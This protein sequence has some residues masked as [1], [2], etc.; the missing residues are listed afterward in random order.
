MNGSRSCTALFSSQVTQQTSRI[1]IFRPSV[2]GWYFDSGYGRWDGCGVD[3][4][5]AFGM[6]GDVPVLR[7][8]DGDGKADIAVYRDGMWYILRSSDGGVTTTGWGGMAQDIPAPAD[9][10]GDGK[11]DIAV[12]RNGLWFIRRSSDG[13]QTVVGWGG[14]PQDLPLY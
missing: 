10:D 6:S 2:G 5:F 11:A 13:V 12:Y 14:L 4:C 7:D 1:G 8:Y 9:Y 3:G